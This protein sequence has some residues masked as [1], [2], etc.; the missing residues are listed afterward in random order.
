MD[1]LMGTLVG[2][3][4]FVLEVLLHTL[5]VLVIAKPPSIRYPTRFTPVGVAGHHKTVSF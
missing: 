2:F 4:Y 3:Q 1:R 5:K